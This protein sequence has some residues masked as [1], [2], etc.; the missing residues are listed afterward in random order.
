MVSITTGL[1]Y[2]QKLLLSKI[3]R[4][5]LI[6]MPNISLKFAIWEEK[7]EWNLAKDFAKISY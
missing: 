5:L 1:I 2:M 4:D 6:F 3:L 7:S